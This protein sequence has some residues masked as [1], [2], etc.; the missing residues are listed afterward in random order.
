MQG[1]IA[2]TLTIFKKRL[3]PILALVLVLIFLG[4]LLPAYISASGNSNVFTF[5]DSS[6]TAAGEGSGYEIDGTDL[7][8]NAAGT[9]TLTGS[10]AEG[11]VTVKKDVTGVTL[12]LN[13]LTLTNSETAPVSC[14][15]SSSVTI[16]AQGENTLTNT[17]DASAE[18]TSDTF[19]GAAIK[20][21]SGASLS[22][23]G[24]GTLNIEGTCKNGIKGA[25]GASVTVS[26]LTLNVTA[27]DNA[28]SSDGSVVVNSGVLTLTAG[29][30]GLKSAPDA[31][32]TESDGIVT[33][34]GG[35]FAITAG[36][37][38]IQG[39]AALTINGGDF[40]VTSGGGC[41]AEL[42]VDASAKGLK[43]DGTLTINDGSFTLD[44]AD[45]ALHAANVTLAAG[46]YTL[47]SGDD[48]VHADEALVVGVQDAENG[49][50]ITV[51][52]S[53]E[54]LEGATVTLY[55]GSGSVTSSDDGINAANGD[56]DSS[57][58]FTLDIYGGSWYVNA[59]GDALDS[60]GDINFHGG[61][62]EFYGSAQNNDS[63]L[64]YDG[65][66]T[67]DGGTFLA[68]G[69]TGMAQTPSTGTYVAFGATG[70]GGGMG[71][72]RPGQTTDGSTSTDGTSSAD[73]TQ[74]RQPADGMTP[75]DGTQST[76]P[77]MGGQ[78]PSA[79][80][81]G[82]S[83]ATSDTAT[84]GGHGQ[85]GNMGGGM[86][87]GTVDA[88][89][90]EFVI[91]EGSAIVIKDSDGNTLYSATGVK[92]ANSVVFAAE[93]LVEGE[94]YTL[95]IDGAE[96]ATATAETG[97]GAKQGFGGGMGGQSPD[98]TTGTQPG[99]ADSSENA[100]AQSSAA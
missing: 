89:T 28:L 11:S 77:S 21:K 12:V 50:D 47:S 3:L 74:L 75:P 92:A 93:A 94:T 25:A 29:N 46:T 2:L 49:P 91:A 59:D 65:S 20:V 5:S 27:A 56:L 34:N 17:E 37:D 6:V 4:I 60:N 86:M 42:A 97:T 61:V 64:D 83:D 78:R 24:S 53:Y 45:D 67:Y 100:T 54:G 84:S 88:S 62:T 13:G 98:G 31:D 69:T 68:V 70:M 18:E 82:S 22:L 76:P 85:R 32:D 66:C 1:G 48:G 96:A 16:E 52:A 99:T 95:Y 43:S 44:C 72:Q 51:A 41:T 9:Y 71:G 35:T 15:K 26:D 55:S 14:G 30:D 39:A 7:T 80:A 10:C 36:G 90:S 8:I 38:G 23:T 19:E 79:P 73:S 40:T 63:A 33:I 57:Y 58:S 87:N 81:D